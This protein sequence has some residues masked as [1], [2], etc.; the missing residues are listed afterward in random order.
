MKI[1]PLLIIDLNI[2]IAFKV[3]QMG[4]IKLGKL[5]YI[6]AKIKKA[7]FTKTS[8]IKLDVSFLEGN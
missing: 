1:K 8:L 4:F 3:A 6:V 7:T 2:N 5:I